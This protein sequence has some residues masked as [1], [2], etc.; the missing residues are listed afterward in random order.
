MI[1]KHI[2]F[3][4]DSL[5]RYQYIQFAY[6]LS[7]LKRLEPYG[8]QPGHPSICLEKEWENWDQF[9]HQTSAILQEAVAGCGNEICDC[10]YNPRDIREYRTLHL[11]FPESLSQQLLNGCRYKR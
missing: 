8:S 4:G 10:S 7:T 9:Y 6:L 11:T 3:A 2:V 1:G 5:T